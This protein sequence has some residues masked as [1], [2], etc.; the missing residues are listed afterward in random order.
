MRRV[1]LLA[2]LAAGFAVPASGAATPKAL[3]AHSLCEAVARVW[4]AEAAPRWRFTDFVCAP[5]MRIQG[6]MQTYLVLVTETNVRTGKA[7]AWE[8]IVAPDGTPLADKELGP[9]PKPKALAA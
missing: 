9:V 2:A 6:G 4:N 5:A 3:F 1:L 7:T 8:I